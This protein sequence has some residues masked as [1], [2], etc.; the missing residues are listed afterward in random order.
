MVDGGWHQS[1]CHHVTMSD[2]YEGRDLIIRKRAVTSVTSHRLNRLHFIR[3]IFRLFRLDLQLVEIE[4]GKW[5]MAF[6]IKLMYFNTL[7]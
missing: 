7:R 1:P 6:K 5:K 2:E 4:N 3:I